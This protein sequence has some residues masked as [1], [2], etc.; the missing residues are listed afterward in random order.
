MKLIISLVTKQGI[1]IDLEVTVDIKMINKLYLGK[2][3]LIVINRLDLG[4]ALITVIK[5]KYLFLN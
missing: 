2:A 1:Q 3:L 5:C 4:K